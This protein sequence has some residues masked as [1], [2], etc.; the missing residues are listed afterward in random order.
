MIVLKPERL[1]VPI[2]YSYPSLLL[3]SSTFTHLSLLLHSSTYSYLSLLLHSS[4]YSYLSLWLHSSTRSHCSQSRHSSFLIASVD[5]EKHFACCC[6]LVFTSDYDK[7]E[8][9]TEDHNL[10]HTTTTV[11]ERSTLVAEDAFFNDLHNDDTT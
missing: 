9:T 4:T 6:W 3:H 5:S 11:I 10:T 2:T 7:D 8:Q 1:V